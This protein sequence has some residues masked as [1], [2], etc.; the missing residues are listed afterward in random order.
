MAGPTELVDFAESLQL[1]ALL[2][3]TDRTNNSGASVRDG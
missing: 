2:L 1:V 3:Q